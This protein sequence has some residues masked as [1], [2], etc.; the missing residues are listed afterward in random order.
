MS[1]D[2]ALG[3][4]KNL[5]QKALFLAAGAIFWPKK[6][7]NG[8]KLAKLTIFYKK[9]QIFLASEF[10]SVGFFWK[11]NCGHLL[12]IPWGTCAQIFINLGHSGAVSIGGALYAPPV[13]AKEFHMPY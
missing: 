8:P 2:T 1:H 10:F 13:A 6:A 3:G 5:G 7:Q 12:G 4:A 9:E 11:N